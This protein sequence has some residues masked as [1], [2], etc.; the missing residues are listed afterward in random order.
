MTKRCETQHMQPACLA[1]NPEPRFIQMLHGCLRARQQVPHSLSETA[2]LPGFF[3]DQTGKRCRCNPG[4]VKIRKNLRQA[5][6]GNAVLCLQPS[7]LCRNLIAVLSWNRHTFRKSASGL[8][9]AMPTLASVRTMLGYK[10]RGW[11]CKIKYLSARRPYRILWR[12]GSLTGLTRVWKMVGDLV[13]GLN[14]LQRCAFMAKLTT[15]LAARLAAQAACA[16]RA[17]RGF[18]QAVA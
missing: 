16:F 9:A 11:R 14:L 7:G 13:R 2:H 1:H 5:F 4:T 8:R 18:G 17:G 15:R 3:G 10:K 12:K 6:F